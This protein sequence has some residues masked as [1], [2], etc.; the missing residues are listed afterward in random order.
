MKLFVS[1]AVLLWLN[2]ACVWSHGQTGASPYQLTVEYDRPGLPVP[3]WRIVI[4]PRGPAEY[5]GKP[6]KGTGD[7]VMTF[8]MSKAGRTRLGMLLSRSNGL[9]PCETKSKGLANMGAKTF[10]YAP[11]NGAAV[12]C[13]FNYTDNKPLGEVLDYLLA[14]VNTLQAGLELERL[15]R[16]D[17]LG[18]DPVMIRLSD[19]VKEGR[20]LEISAIRPTLQ[21]L[22]TDDALLERVRTRAQ[23][24]LALA[25]IQDSKSA[26]Q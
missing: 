13:T 22:L 3:H 6:E 15:H 21:S 16:Y 7:G 9:Q 14:T 8:D 19:D 2:L 11:V 23:Q 24:L 10:T 1:V 20:A 26:G 25:E 12:H 18:L 5:T 17:R 4:P